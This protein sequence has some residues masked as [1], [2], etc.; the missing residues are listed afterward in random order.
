MVSVKVDPIIVQGKLS[1]VFQAPVLN[2]WDTAMKE[3]LA[4]VKASSPVDNGDL[5]RGY[6]AGKARIARG[7][8]KARFINNTANS[9]YRER[10]RGPGK[11]PPFENGSSLFRWAKKRGI[12]PYLIA[13]KI[14]RVGTDR[15]RSNKNPLG[16]DRSSTPADIRIN[17]GSPLA[18]IAPKIIQDVN[19]I[20]L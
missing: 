18:K 2:I 11:M 10:G 13:R 7:E 8:F 3:A 17:P 14:S 20:K 15:W 6:K 16:I 12:S 19:Q 1:E 4:E 5:R 9:L